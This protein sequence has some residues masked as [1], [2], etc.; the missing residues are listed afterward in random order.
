MNGER[1]VLLLFPEL[2]PM[3]PASEGAGDPNE[4]VPGNTDF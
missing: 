1:P 4:F 2:T 3:P